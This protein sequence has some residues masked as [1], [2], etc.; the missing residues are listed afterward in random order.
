MANILGLLH[1]KHPFLHSHL[2]DEPA[3][4]FLKLPLIYY[5]FFSSVNL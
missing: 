2:P 5:I 4:V 3:D 1:C